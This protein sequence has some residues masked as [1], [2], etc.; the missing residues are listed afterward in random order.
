MVG[1]TLTLAPGID[2]TGR[3]RVVETANT[4]SLAGVA[5][6]LWPVLRYLM[7]GWQFRMQRDD[8]GRLSSKNVPPGRFAVEVRYLPDNC[9]VQNVTYGGQ[10]M[11][12]DGIEITAPA[13][14]EVVL[15]ATAARINGRVTDKAGWP[16]P[17]TAV[18]LIPSGVGSPIESAIARDDGA[19]AFDHLRPGTYKLMAWEDVD[20]GA[21][22]DP[23]FRKPYDNQAT[24]VKVGPREQQTVQLH[25]IL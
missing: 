14:L 1:L 12:L 10:E 8:D 11:T 23:E 24:E 9:F 20:W 22:K 16:A 3:V 7:L 5:V 13:P 15:S 25:V 17:W 6:D 19:F 2:L 21:W 18:A 4:V